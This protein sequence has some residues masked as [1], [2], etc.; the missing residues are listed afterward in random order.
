V[1]EK[2]ENIKDSLALERRQT[3]MATN[4]AVALINLMNPTG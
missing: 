2:F 1:A 3:K 4:K